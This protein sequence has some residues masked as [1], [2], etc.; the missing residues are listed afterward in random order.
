MHAYSRDERKMEKKAAL[1]LI[2]V[3]E[4]AILML[5]FSW[6]VF[7]GE[8]NYKVGSQNAKQKVM[9]REET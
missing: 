5:Q 6:L 4:P 3:L 9:Q 8:K 7:R 1:S 2:K